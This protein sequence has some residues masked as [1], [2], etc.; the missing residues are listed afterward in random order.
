MSEQVSADR[1]EKALALHEEGLTIVPAHPIEK[2]PLVDWARFQHQDVTDELI[3]LWT[4]SARWRDCNWAIVTGKEVV[5]VDADS[6][7][8]T[9]WG[10]G[11]PATYTASR[12]HVQGRP[13]LL[14]GG[15][16]PAH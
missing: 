11:Q 10:R 1:R 13:L 16:R 3:E 6:A 7:E 15:Q 2:R 8:A 14:P 12:S 4:S 9:A 5:V